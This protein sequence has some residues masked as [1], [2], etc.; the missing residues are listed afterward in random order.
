[1]TRL[2]LKLV[3]T[4][5]SSY[6]MDYYRDVQGLIYNLLRGSEFNCHDKKG[7]KFFSFSQIFPFHSLHEGDRR[8]L[9][10][11]SPNADFVSYIKEQLEYLQR[12]RIGA[13]QF[14]LDYANVVRVNGSPNNLITGTPIVVR[15]QQREQSSGLSL[16]FVTGYWCK[17]YP[18]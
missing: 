3:A 5:N 2:L 9:I 12:I 13:M 8:N 18:V 11:A 7:Y 10:I 4:E 6:E 15:L 14:K 16:Q 17:R 1:M